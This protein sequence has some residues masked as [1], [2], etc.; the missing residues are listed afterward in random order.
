LPDHEIAG[1][2]ADDRARC[3]PQVG[4]DELALA[5]VRRLLSRYRIDDFANVFGFVQMKGSRTL[6]AFEA[7]RANFSQAMVVHGARPPLLLDPFTRG[8]NAASRLAGDDQ[9]THGAFTEGTA[10]G[11]LPDFGCGRFGEAQGV[12]W[13]AAD[14]G[15]SK[16]VD[17]PQP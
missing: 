13:R 11:S 4:D 9:Q 8:G 5:P 2:I 7:D 15:C 1:S 10:S 12:S 6:T 17:H 16:S 3:A 14:D